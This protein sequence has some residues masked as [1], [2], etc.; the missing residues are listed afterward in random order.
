MTRELD[1]MLMRSLRRL[2]FEGEE[3]N[4]MY[5]LFSSFPQPLASLILDQARRAQAPRRPKN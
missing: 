4:R 5:L 3:L 2:G 1:K